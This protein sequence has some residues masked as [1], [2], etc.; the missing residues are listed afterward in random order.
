MTQIVETDEAGRLVLPAEMLGEVKPHARYTVEVMGARLVVESEEMASVSGALT[1]AE[2]KRG[3]DTFVKQV[4]AVTP[5]SG[6]TAR[7]E[8]TDM[9]NARGQGLVSDY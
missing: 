4:A 3:W 2:W 7:E 9:R 5:S 6:R 1:S 8:L